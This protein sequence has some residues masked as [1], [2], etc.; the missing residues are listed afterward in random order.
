MIA[1]LK[2]SDADW[3]AVVYGQPITKLYSYARLIRPSDGV[4][5]VHTDWVLEKLIP[6]ICL[7]ATTI[8]PN[9]RLPQEQ[10]A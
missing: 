10:V 4:H 1:W 6:S 3:E 2:L 5:Q 8:P 7:T 9:W